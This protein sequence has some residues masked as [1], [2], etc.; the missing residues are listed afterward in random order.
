M[1][2]VEKA[3]EQ[4][5]K[6]VALRPENPYF[7]T[8]LAKAYGTAHQYKKSGANLEKA[9]QICEE[10]NNLY[11]MG[12]IYC[13]LGD[14]A[15][16]DF[17]LNT[18]E[19]YTRKSLEINQQIGN[20]AA[21]GF[22]LMLLS[23]IEQLQGRI[24]QSEADIRQALEII[25][26]LDLPNVKRICYL[27]LSENAVAQQ[28]Y[29]DNINYWEDRDLIEI[30]IASQTTLRAAEEMAAKYETA[31]KELEIENQKQIIARQNLQRGLLAGGVAVCAMILVL[32]WFMLRLRN[33]RNLALAERN[34]ALSETNATKDKF[35]SIISHDLKNPAVAQ[36]D[37]LR[38]LFKNISQWDSDTLTG[39]CGE[40]LRSADNQVELLYNLLNWAQVQTGRMTYQPEPFDLVQALRSDLALIRKMAENKGVA[41]ETDMPPQ[42]IVNG[43]AG[44]IVTV[45][46]NLLTN[47][48]KF[49][50]EGG[51]VTLAISPYWG[52]ENADDTDDADFHRKHNGK[53]LC[54]SASSASSVF[55]NPTKYTV[56]VADT[57]IG[58]DVE[59]APTAPRPGTAGET[60]TGL[61][62]IVCKE[63][64]EKHRSE[65]HVESRVGEGSR[66][67]FEL[68]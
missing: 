22:S 34:R 61:G 7:L 4:G 3:I 36:R 58:M 45:V 18:A 14:N 37:A 30:N 15:L 46:R 5:E 43:D 32:L 49:T 67:W 57:G 27:I 6:A 12:Y 8:G 50:P 42:A 33:R 52:Q 16:L 21:Y 65:L 55:K 35:F 53:N 59:G 2:T 29:H 41:L 26:E 56:S 63:M 40:L 1:R 60:G 64:L 44:M 62:L 9:L 10:Q 54:K 51:R 66:F 20:T 25:E 23:K 24:T 38:L 48:V 68:L 28:R 31:K 11:V 13:E 47:A 17:D 39:Y 19:K